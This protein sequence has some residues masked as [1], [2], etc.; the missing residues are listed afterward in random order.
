MLAGEP[1]V[2]T[3]DAATAAVTPSRSP[4]PSRYDVNHVL[5]TGQSLSVGAA[6]VPALT[7]VQPYANL[8]FAPGVMPGGEHLTRFVPLQES[9]LETMSSA[10][11]NLVARLAREED[12]REHDLLVSLH[13]K[14]STGYW[15]LKRG[16]K[17][18]ATGMAQVT[19]GRDIA[20]ANG[21]TYVVSAVTT[22]HGESDHVEKNL[23]YERD[24]VTW[25]ADYERDVRAITGQTDP[26]PL[27]ETQMS[28]WNHYGAAE[29]VIPLAQ[30]AAHVAAPGK[31]ILVGPKY[32]L[33][34]AADGVHLSSEGYRHMGED[35]AKAY[36]RVVVEGRTWEPLRPKTIT[37]TGAVVTVTFHVP[38][39]PLVFDTTRVSDPG[40][41][42]F[43]FVDDQK[44][45]IT[46]VVLSGPDTVTI[47][48]SGEP[49]RATRLQYAS[50]GVPNTP[51]GPRTGPRGNLRDSDATVSASGNELFAWCV[52]FDV[53]VD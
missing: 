40:D 29:S 48:L 28:S 13:G 35:Y 17:A 51:A 49:G 8:M 1:R 4:A 34:Y 50:I 7:K 18:Y 43:R 12:Q 22:V 19:R 10:F 6:G 37:R 26:V 39:P 14:S 31:V 32:H 23:R 33:P 38:T 2:P 42:G 24:L 47:T 5:S 52:H 3:I 15:G 16:S 44:T 41:Y 20:K 45:R 21:Q 46:Q 25:Q 36:R 9:G 27:F 53:P 11:A 30:L